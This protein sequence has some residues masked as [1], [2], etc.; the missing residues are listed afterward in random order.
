MPFDGAR[1]EEQPRA[2]LGI[3]ESVA[4]QP[5]DLVFLGCEVVAG[6]DD[7]L[8]HPLTSCAQLP[9]GALGERLDA[10][11]AQHLVCEAQ[12]PACVHAATLAAQ[13]L[14]VE[15]M[16]AGQVDAAAAGAEAGDRLPVELLCFAAMA[17]ERARARLHPERPVGVAD[18]SALRERVQRGKRLAHGARTR[19]GLDQLRQ[20]P[21][22]E[23]DQ[24]AVL[25]NAPAARQRLL[26][27]AQAVVQ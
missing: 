24:L 7:A 2:D 21:W 16:R 17:Q 6:L 8:A 15:E 19:S 4:R 23:A 20:R 22:R 9:A 5:R 3:G 27:S 25:E 1:T 11:V 13:P 12:M 10:H 14:A 26:V 18:V